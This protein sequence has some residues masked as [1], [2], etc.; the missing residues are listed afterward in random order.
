MRISAASG[1]LDSTRL[2]VIRRFRASGSEKIG[3]SHLS[4]ALRRKRAPP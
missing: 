3:K 2:D 1:F 4:E